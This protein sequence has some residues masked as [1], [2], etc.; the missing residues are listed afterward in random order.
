MQLSFSNSSH[1]VTRKLAKLVQK[2]SSN[3]AVSADINNSKELLRFIEDVADTIVIL[4][5]HVDIISDFTPDLTRKLRKLAEE[6]DFL[7]FEDRKFSDIGSTVRHQVSD[8]IYRIADWADIIN[9]HMLPGPGI[10]K[11]LQ[12]GC[13]GKN[14]GLLLLAQ[15]SSQGNLFNQRYTQTVVQ[16]ALNNKKFV[17]G[18]IA[19]EK[20]IHN[21]DFVTMT[22]GISL[23]NTTDQFDQN[24]CQ[25]F[26]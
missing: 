17:M 8:G 18:F 2:K 22:P 24:Y 14:I 26:I 5:I 25:L 16:H 10:I 4:K 20:L 9:A 23:S 1:I 6:A 13:Y 7:I 3:L 11:G 21:E 15:M 12:E 19:Q